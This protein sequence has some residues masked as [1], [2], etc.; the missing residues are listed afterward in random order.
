M[1]NRSKAPAE[2]G[3]FDVKNR[4][5]RLTAEDLGLFTEFLFD[6]YARKR[7]KELPGYWNTLITTSYTIEGLRERQPERDPYEKIRAYYKKFS[8]LPENA[9]VIKTA[10]ADLERA[11]AKYGNTL[12]N[13]VARWE[14]KRR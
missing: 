5:S 14:E 8:S 10:I 2:K 7:E 11:E 3:R 12:V 1:V 4:I 9:Q 6:R 13:R